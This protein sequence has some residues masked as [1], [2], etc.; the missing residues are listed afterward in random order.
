MENWGSANELDRLNPA[1]SDQ[2]V[3]DTSDFG[4]PSCIGQSGRE[5]S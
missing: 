2:Q 4:Q 1:H 5:L 3:C